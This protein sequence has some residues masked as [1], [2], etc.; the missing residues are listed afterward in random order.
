[1]ATLEPRLPHTSGISTAV[2]SSGTQSIP[3]GTSLVISGPKDPGSTQEEEAAALRSAFEEARGTCAADLRATITAR[4]RA[5]DEVA[6]LRKALTDVL[7]KAEGRDDDIAR[8]AASA[9][10]IDRQ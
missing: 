3:A 5:P 10:Y 4:D 8:I 7:L 2:R 9:L 6:R 1:P